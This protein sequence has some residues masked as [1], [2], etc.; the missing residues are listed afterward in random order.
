MKRVLRYLVPYKK[1]ITI[2]LIVKGLATIIELMLP[3]LLAYVIDKIIPLQQLNLVILF[4]LLMLLTALGAYISNIIA[5]RFAARISTNAIYDLRDDTY[6]KI[7][8]FSNQVVDNFTI[9]SLISRMTS[10][11][12]HIYRMFNVIQR[13]GIRAPILLVGSLF[14]MF[15]I[16]FSLAIV[17]IGLLP[18]IVLAI[19]LV[20]KKGIPFYDKLQTSLDNMVRVVRENIAGIRIIKALGKEGNEKEKYERVNQEVSNKE[21]KAGFIVATLNP[22]MNLLLNL[23]LVS[24]LYV[25]SLRVLD[26]TSQTGSI[27]AFLSYFTLI[28]NSFLALNRIFLLLSRA[29]ASAS[30]IAILLDTEDEKAIFEPTNKQSDHH[31][32][33]NNV[34]FSYNKVAND[35]ENISFKIKHNHTFGIIGATGSGKSTIAQLLMRM[36]DV[37]EG[38]VLIN[39]QD[40]RSM[41]EKKLRRRFGVVFQ[42]DAL[43]SYSIKENIAFGR[44]LENDQLIEA[45]EY[46]QA[47]G[48]IDQLSDRYEAKVLRSGANFSGGQ[49]QRML[50][51]RALADHPEI[52]VLDDA[53]SAL[54]Y[55]TDANLRKAIKESYHATAIIITQRV[56]SVIHADQILVID[57][58][59]IIGLGTHD[60]LA[61]SCEEYKELIKLQL[62]GDENELW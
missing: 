35:I 24:I 61:K 46:A 40:I 17:L 48:F 7:M 15:I 8:H 37:D 32:E 6:T 2:G 38:E 20:S 53:S 22:T 3:F 5:N 45:A 9:P 25:G 52:I 47:S 58:G 31:I 30:R 41:N 27:L 34:S 62:G 23:G 21:K 51:A 16:D 60:E 54:D 10:D 50:I 19:V 11:T 55:Q 29:G 4:G 13:I 39:G 33:F 14:F 44:K 18:L 1:T 26:G 56:A 49:K 43:F 12:Y 36:Y 59:R 57:H 28:L 42:N